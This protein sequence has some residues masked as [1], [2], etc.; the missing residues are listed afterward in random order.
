MLESLIKAEK[1]GQKPFEMFFLAIAMTL[2]AAALAYTV[3]PD[4]AGHL[5]IAF[6]CIGAAPI[7][8]RV[9][10]L[11]EKE[12]ADIHEN[13]VRMLARHGDMFEIFGW[14]FLGVIV[15]TSFLFV[16]M[17]TSMEQPMFGPQMQELQSI[18]GM[19]TGRVT[20]ECDMLCLFENNF[21]VLLLVLVFSFVFGAGA[22]YIITWNASIVGVLIGM[23][24][25]AETGNLL[26]NYIV[27][28][29]I[30]IVKLFPHGIFEVGAYFFG[31]LAGG[32]LSAMIVRGHWKRTDV[33]KDIL[34]VFLIAT[35]LVAIGAVIEGM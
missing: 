7:M 17:P 2:I 26:L 29:P 11:E 24:A 35:L 21:G 18:R 27:A 5:I 14:F 34:A 32:M 6:V 22:V 4:S 25:K 20:S 28:L 33:L 3:S 8:V 9:I 16:I 10:T 23:T 31:G 13:E 12:S 19:A 1:M 15:A 30:S